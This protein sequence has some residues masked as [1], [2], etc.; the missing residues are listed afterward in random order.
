V[1]C[2]HIPPLL[3]DSGSAAYHGE[4]GLVLG[5][6]RHE[7]H[8]ET[9]QLPPGGTVLL[10]TDGLVE[11][12]DVPLDANLEK[13]RVAAEAAATLDVEAFSNGIIS[14][15]G[16]REDDVAMIVLRRLPAGANGP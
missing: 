8:T 5:L 3:V 10:V 1:N 4:G 6:P 15:F 12:R 14:L 7:A 16:L 13:L 11:D 2:G 9:A